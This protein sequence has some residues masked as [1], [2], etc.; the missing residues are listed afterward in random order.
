MFVHP[1]DLAEAVRLARPLGVDAHRRHGALAGDPGSDLRSDRRDRGGRTQV[2]QGRPQPNT[3]VYEGHGR[4]IG[5]EDAR[6]SRARRRHVETVTADQIVIA[7]GGR[8]RIPPISGSRRPAGGRPA[9]LGHGHADR[10]S[11]GPGAVIGGGYVG[12]RVRPRLRRRSA[13]RCPGATRTQLLSRTTTRTSPRPTPRTPRRATTSAS[14]PGGLGAARH[15]RRARWPDRD[16][17]RRRVGRGRH[18]LLATGREPNGHRLDVRAHRPSASTATVAYRSTVPAAPPSTASSPSATC[19]ATGSSSTSP[20]TR[21]GSSRTICCTPSAMRTADHRFVP[22]AVFTDPQIASVGLTEEQARTGRRVRH[23]HARYGGIAAGWAREDTTDFLKVLADP[24]TGML[25]GAHVIGPEAAT[26]IQP[27]I[28]SMSF[29]MPGPRDRP[30]P[31]LD[32]PRPVRGRRERAAR[33]DRRP[34]ARSS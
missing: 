19:P 31:V 29:G 26:V 13:R 18:L 4:F 2:P 10:R 21:R 33:A 17:V 11:A 14:T 6:P 9:H 24:V 20:T 3:T 34:P 5:T 8:P 22:A 27:L 15:R 23:R 32:P 28:Q 25:I 7:A 1:A 12:R 30:R 16:A